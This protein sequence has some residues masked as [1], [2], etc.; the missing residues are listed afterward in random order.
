M[1]IWPAADRQGNPGLRARLENSERWLCRP[2]RPDALG[3]FERSAPVSD[4]CDSV[5]ITSDRGVR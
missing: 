5:V 4:R 3:L 2:E 1:F